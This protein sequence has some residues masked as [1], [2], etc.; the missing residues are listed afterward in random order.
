MACSIIVTDL[1]PHSKG[2]LLYIA[3][4]DMETGQ[5]VRPLPYL[6]ERG[7]VAK[8]IVPGAMLEMEG[9]FYGEPPFVEDFFMERLLSVTPASGAAL[10]KALSAS[11][12]A[13]L[14]REFQSMIIDNRYI[15]QDQGVGR[16]LATV[17]CRRNKVKLTPD[18]RATHTHI[19]R[20]IFQ[21]E[22]DWFNIPLMQWAWYRA[23]LKNRA[24]AIS[25]LQARMQRYEELF[26]R[27]GLARAREG[28]Y[29][30]QVNGVYGV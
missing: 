10:K 6:S 18:N 14:A 4:V 26:V 1:T 28:M 11:C 17:R 24:D 20:M 5:N 2:G 23:G 25:E 16:S 8:G 19:I 22:R 27:I 3:G 7:C 9:E 21:N 29:S 30:L 12:R 13:S 15:K